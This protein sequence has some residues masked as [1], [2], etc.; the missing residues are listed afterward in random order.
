MGLFLIFQSS[1]R[2]SRRSC[3]TITLDVEVEADANTSFFDFPVK[4]SGL[5]FAHSGFRSAFVD[6]NR[7]CYEDEALKENE[8]FFA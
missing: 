4:F 8:I 7:V 2:K 6:Q 1:R 5:A 3:R